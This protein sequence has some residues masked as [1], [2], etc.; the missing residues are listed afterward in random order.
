MDDLRIACGRP[1]SPAS[2][3][4]SAR[5]GPGPAGSARARR[6]TRPPAAP[7]ASGPPPSGSARRSRLRPAPSRRARRRPCRSSPAAFL[8]QLPQ[9]LVVDGPGVVQGE[10]QPE[11]RVRMD[12][13]ADRIGLLRQKGDV[14]SDERVGQRLQVPRPFLAVGVVPAV[15]FLGQFQQPGPAV[16]PFEGLAVRLRRNS[17]PRPAG[18]WPSGSRPGP[19][20]SARFSGRS[21]NCRSSRTSIQWPCTDECQ[22]KQP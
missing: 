19:C 21:G 17:R 4:T 9:L 16:G 15:Q 3:A 5:P 22:S 11:G 7:A 12:A 18:S 1:P 8:D 13:A 6:G 10:R 2:A 14:A 20:G